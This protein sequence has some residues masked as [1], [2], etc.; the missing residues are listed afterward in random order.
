MYIY[1]Y[2]FHY[3]LY[4]FQSYLWVPALALY[5]QIFTVISDIAFSQEQS[6]GM[7][8]SLCLLPRCQYICFRKKYFQRPWKYPQQRL[9]EVS[10]KDVE[11]L[12]CVVILS[13]KEDGNLV[14]RSVVQFWDCYSCH[15]QIWSLILEGL[16]NILAYFSCRLFKEQKVSSLSCF[17]YLIFASNKSPVCFFAGLLSIRRSITHDLESIVAS[18]NLHNWER[19]SSIG[20]E[21][22]PFS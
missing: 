14:W 16:S 11:Y 15:F 7:H 10:W 22:I 3:I 19:E 6:V 17:Q 8:C 5:I 21:G 4:W 13:F 20:V 1:R 9:S 2:I 18:S 12:T